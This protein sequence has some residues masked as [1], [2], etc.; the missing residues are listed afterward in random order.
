MS[1]KKRKTAS[2]QMPKVRVKVEKKAFDKV[3]GKLIRSKP[4]NR[5]KCLAST[6]NGES[7]LP[8]R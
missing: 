2:S 6:G 1:G 4:V 5:G 8:L 3:L 7:V